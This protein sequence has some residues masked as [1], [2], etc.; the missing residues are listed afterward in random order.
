MPPY[1]IWRCAI[2]FC[3]AFSLAFGLSVNYAWPTELALPKSDK[4]VCYVQGED[5]PRNMILK[6]D[7]RCKSHLR[8]VPLPR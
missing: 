5:G 7:L 6:D 2:A 8:W 4:G 1:L 3:I